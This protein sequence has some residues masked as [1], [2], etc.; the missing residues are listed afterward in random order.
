MRTA[1]KGFLIIFLTINSFT[2]GEELIEKFNNTQKTLGLMT[3]WSEV[4]FGFPYPDKLKSLDWDEK[5]QEYIPRVINAQNINDYYFV[6]MEFAALLDDSHTSV[7]PPWG[8]FKP[9]YDTPPVEISV[10]KDKFYIYRTGD[11]DEI[12]SQR[13]FPGTEILEIGNVPIQTYFEENVLKYYSQGSKQANEAILVVYLLNG[14]KEDKV[15][16]KVKD[17]NGIS[18]DI[19]L[20]R[21]STNKDGSPFLYQ[22]V[23]NIFVENSITTRELDNNILYIKIPNFENENIGDE[24]QSVIDNLDISKTRGLI[25]DVRNNLGGSSKVCNKIVECLIDK[26]VTSPL[27]NYPHYIAA[28][29]AWGKKEIW[30]TDIN[31]I[32]PRDGKKYLGPIVV[33]TNAITNSTAEDLA[34]ELKYGK[35]ATIIGQITSG[36]AGNT[37]QFELPFGGTFQLATFKATL[38]DDSEYIGIGI[39]PDIEIITTVDDVIN[40][41][42]KSLDTSI[43]LLKKY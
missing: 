30:S 4:K 31:T 28:Y 42:D 38:P 16:L 39:T 10:I 22:F 37:L 19:V 3:I 27:M 24:F 13:V 20:S 36:G 9:G 18:R 1:I 26:P 12:E 5:V 21:N 6:L 34:I 15:Y 43:E 40:N 11:S 41:Y 33:L 2:I 7:I 29:K 14:P 32:N 35:R 17:V 25:L 23:N 8:H